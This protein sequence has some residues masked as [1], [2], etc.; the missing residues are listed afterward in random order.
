MPA[1]PATLAGLPSWMAG[2]FDIL[3]DA[4]FGLDDDGRVRFLNHAAARLVD[5]EPGEA[6]GRLLQDLLPLLDEVTQEPFP[7]RDGHGWP[8]V[9]APVPDP[10]AA[11][12]RRGRIAGDV[13]NRL[14]EAVLGR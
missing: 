2:V 8:A 14:L 6:A 13:A 12:R 1:Q 3:S 4:L 7:P 10:R 11:R 5:R 9:A